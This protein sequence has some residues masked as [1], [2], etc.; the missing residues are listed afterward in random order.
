[1][2]EDHY[3]YAWLQMA[4]EEMI[5]PSMSLTEED[6]NFPHARIYIINPL[7][8]TEIIVEEAVAMADNT[9]LKLLVIVNNDNSYDFQSL[10]KQKWRTPVIGVTASTGKNLKK[11]VC[12]KG[13]EERIL[14]LVL[15]MMDEPDYPVLKSEIRGIYFKHNAENGL[16]CKE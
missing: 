5:L 2:N 14:E 15:H 4:S 7:K 3:S 1:M 11:H 9:N 12:R 6:E 10:P 13:V 8:E 16:L